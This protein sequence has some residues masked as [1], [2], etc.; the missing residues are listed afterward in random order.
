M[1][2]VNRCKIPIITLWLAGKLEYQLFAFILSVLNTI[3]EHATD[4]VINEDVKF[5]S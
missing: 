3:T 5:Y 1:S 2:W 4:L